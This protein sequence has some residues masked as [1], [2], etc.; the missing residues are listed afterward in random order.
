MKQ[1]S[2]FIVNEYTEPEELV[3]KIGETVRLRA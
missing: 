1:I 2:R 3:N